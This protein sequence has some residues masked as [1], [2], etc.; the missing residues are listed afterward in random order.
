MKGGQ[1]FFG[2]WGGIS[3]V[4]STLRALLTLDLPLP[5]ITRLLSANVARRFRLPAKGGIAVGAD[6]DLALVD[7]S[8]RLPLRADELLDRH[9]AS[10]YV[11]RLFRGVV[12]HTLV[13]GRTVFRDGAAVGAPVGRFVR[14]AR[15]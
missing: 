4:Q 2:A 13:R 14:P 10:P 1:D 5:L 7:M 15:E 9:R 12:K 8:V 11:G 6:A 3:G